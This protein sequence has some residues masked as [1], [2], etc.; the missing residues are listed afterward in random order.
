MEKLENV[1]LVVIGSARIDAFM[2]I[3]DDKADTFCKLDTK[4][5]VVELSYASKIGM[6]RVEFLLGGN[7]ANV[8]VGT[9]RMG[10][11]SMLIAEVGT[12]MMGD[13]TKSELDKEVDTS[14]VTQADGVPAGFG[15]VIV[16]QGERTILSYYPPVTPKFPQGVC[17]AQWAYLTSTGEKFEEYYDDV[18]EWLD[19]CK[20][21]LAFNPGGRQIAKG[22]EWM[23]KFLGK[24]ELMIANRQETEKIVGMSDT[25][26]KEKELI[27]EMC[28]LGP[29]M[30]VV[31]DGM[32]GAYAYDGDKFWHSGVLPIDAIERTGAGDAFSTG[33]L[34]ALLN[35]KSLKDA[36]LQ[37]T[38]N[39]ASVIGYVG[40]EDGLLKT[41]Q[42]PEWFE[43]AEECEVKVVEI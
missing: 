27:G 22:K 39:S 18:Y 35:G 4:K 23:S 16:Y 6:K 32:D 15:A 26:G 19:G 36:L 25:Y 2:F 3:P 29:R 34:G 5:C 10:V 21:K 38:I 20:P 12:G 43:R 9:K 42:L 17:G 40:P 31:T 14:F 24:T 41:E 37:G 13:Y 11:E 7:G 28:R 30:V 1:Q 8:A 33:L